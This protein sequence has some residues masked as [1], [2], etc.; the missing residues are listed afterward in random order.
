MTV[1]SLDFFPFDMLIN[2]SLNDWR[3]NTN[4]VCMLNRN[5]M[6]KSFVLK[7]DWKITWMFFWMHLFCLIS[8]YP[9][10]IWS[11]E[12]LPYI[13]SELITYLWSLWKTLT[14]SLFSMNTWY[15]FHWQKTFY[16]LHSQAMLSLNTKH[17]KKVAP[18]LLKQCV[19]LNRSFILFLCTNCFIKLFL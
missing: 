13:Y 10:K 8:L 17:F 9:V 18:V 14:H 12:C 19:I 4:F 16:L 5:R 3:R 2:D 11:L 1:L 15:S 6:K 7:A